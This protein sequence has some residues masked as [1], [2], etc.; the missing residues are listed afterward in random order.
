MLILKSPCEAY[1]MLLDDLLAKASAG[2]FADPLDLAVDIPET[3]DLDELV[4]NCCWNARGYSH[5]TASPDNP[6]PLY[7]SFARLPPCMHRMYANIDLVFAD[8][9]VKKTELLR[10]CARN[11][12]RTLKARRLENKDIFASLE[13]ESE[14]REFKRKASQLRAFRKKKRLESLSP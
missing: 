7:F 1:E 10:L 6:K 3:S 4:E 8:W 9:E 13:T 5:P 2:K 12:K 11:T 14:R